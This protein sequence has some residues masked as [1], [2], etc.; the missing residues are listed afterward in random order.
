MSFES[1]RK[2][3][4]HR[5][6]RF[7]GRSAALSCTRSMSMCTPRLFGFRTAATALDVAIEP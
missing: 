7:A 1:P 5:P 6:S 4:R 3:D 2:G